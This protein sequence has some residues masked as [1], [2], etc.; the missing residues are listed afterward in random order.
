MSDITLSIHGGKSCGNCCWNPDNLN[1]F[2]PEDYHMGGCADRVVIATDKYG[3]LIGAW[4]YNREPRKI[5]RSFGTWV[6]PSFRKIGLAK[7]MWEF[8]IVYENAKKVIVTVMTDR[9]YSL[10]DSMKKRFPK[11]RWDVVEGAD[12]KLRK[13]SKKR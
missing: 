6:S 5:I 7:K 4:K 11:V 13:L 9:G 8:G 3:H 2:G 1:D 10:V 12:R